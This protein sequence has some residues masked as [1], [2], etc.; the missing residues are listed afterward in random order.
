MTIHEKT[1]IE[2]IVG[3]WLL[4]AKRVNSLANDDIVKGNEQVHAVRATVKTYETC[5][6]ELAE[7]LLK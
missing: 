6:Q 3:K 1:K 2:D 4:M 7:A 5:A